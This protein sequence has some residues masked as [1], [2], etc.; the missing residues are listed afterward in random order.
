MKHYKNKTKVN[1]N[2]LVN[3]SRRMFL[4]MAFVGVTPTLFLS[5]FSLFYKGEIDYIFALPVL[6]IM[7]CTLI[8]VAYLVATK[9]IVKPILNIR[10]TLSKVESG[11]Y[12]QRLSINSNEGEISYIKE[13]LNGMLDDLELMD[14]SQRD[15]IANVSHELRTPVSAIQAL[16]ENI[17]D[18]IIEPNNEV[19]NQLLSKIERLSDLLSFL[20]DLSRIDAG[21]ASLNRKVFEL[22]N[23]L[24]DA[25][26]PLSTYEGSKKLKFIINVSPSNLTIEADKN[27]FSQVITNLVANAIKHSP[28]R[29]EILLKADKQGDEIVIDVVDSGI[30]IEKSERS[31]VFKKFVKGESSLEGT[32]IGL[33]IVQWAVHLHGGEVSVKDSA[34]GARFEVRMPDLRRKHAQ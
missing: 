8:C 2:F 9:I 33:S 4:L 26:K 6:F 12:T 30:G 21:A 1:D 18:G 13:S 22:G 32:G 11:N 17:A 10:D 25:V 7:S 20:L 24:E 15:L 34:Q 16:T 19:I 27:R 5:A 14:K 31:R 28:P 29:S 23:F 3:I